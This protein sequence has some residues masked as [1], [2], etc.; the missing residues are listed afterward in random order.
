MSLEL[1][2]SK[3][4]DGELSSVEDAK[5]RQMLKENPF[6]KEKFDQSVELHLD[7]LDDC[8]N[9]QVP[10]DLLRK[11]E[12]TVMMKIFAAPA[13]A[14][15]N[16]VKNKSLNKFSYRIPAMA[17]MVAFFAFVSFLRIGDNNY[18]RSIELYAPAISSDMVAPAEKL[19]I[20][21]AKNSSVASEVSISNEVF[22]ETDD[23]SNGNLISEIDLD[24]K[25]S[26]SISSSNS[27]SVITSEPGITSKSLT[28]MP[29]LD[30]DET[31][32]TNNTSI[33][34]Q[35]ATSLLI[36]NK[37]AASFNSNE[38]FHSMQQSALPSVNYG[39]SGGPEITAIQLN[40]LIS[41]DF[42]RTGIATS[43][44]N[45]MTS[46]SQS[47]GYNIGK[48]VT[49]GIEFGITEFNYDYIKYIPLNSGQEYSGSSSF[50]VNTPGSGNGGSGTLIN[51]PVTLQR[52]IQFFW[53]MAF[54]ESEIVAIGDLSLIGRLGLGATNDGPLG[55][56]R[57][58][59]KYLIFSNLAI[60]AGTEGRAF[61]M[62]TPLLENSITTIS[63]YGFNYG[64][65]LNF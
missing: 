34:G 24:T 7:M 62:K 63:S 46:M 59:A 21:K 27:E 51:V 32:A 16:T 58:T 3:Y 1:L 43:K 48:Y 2:I 64:V 61:M 20:N 38:S 8:S 40:T 52:Q 4:I 36:S 12:E 22:V 35:S 50:G 31:V 30:V 18:F 9:I 39:F 6:S 42:A 33:D 54:Y 45:P 26:S 65:Q 47:L 19:Q 13:F 56:G 25:P 23:L 17:A 10:Y 60:T 41:Q 37:Q 44:N 57:I 11:T 5:L 15:S 49:I 53:G 14:Q 29:N 28:I 55:M